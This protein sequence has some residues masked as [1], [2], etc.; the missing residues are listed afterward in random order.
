MQ[1]VY[2]KYT[3]CCLYNI[4]KCSTK[5]LLYKIF[6]LKY[7]DTVNVLDLLFAKSYTYNSLGFDPLN[8]KNCSTTSV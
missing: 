7:V 1:L 4:P 3:A 8:C 5:F 6:G 2:Q